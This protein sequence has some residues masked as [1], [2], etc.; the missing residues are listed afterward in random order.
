MYWIKK[1]I[2]ILAYLLL[3][4]TA[5]MLGNTLLTWLSSAEPTINSTEFN[6]R[7]QVHW[8]S[9]SKALHYFY[10]AKRAVSLRV[11]S[12]GIFASQPLDSEPVHYA[13]E[14]KLLDASE[15]V[16]YQGVYHH[17]AK[18]V[19]IGQ[20]QQVKQII[21]DREVLH[22]ASGQ[23]FYLPREHVANATVLSLRLIPESAQLQG[24]VVRVH[25]KTSNSNTN[26]TKAWLQR[27]TEWRQRVMNYHSIGATALTDEEKF[28]AVRYDWQKLAPQGL[29]NVGFKA[30]RLYESLP[31]NVANPEFMSQVN[32]DKLV[33]D[34][35][36]QVS[37]RAMPGSYSVVANDPSALQFMWHDLTQQQA[38]R[39]L[40]SAPVTP[41][42]AKVSITEPGLI[43][44]A[45]TAPQ[46][47]EIISA[48]E[49]KI[50]PLHSYYYAISQQQ[51]VSFN[52]EPDSNLALEWR[53]PIG[54]ELTIKLFANGQ[55]QEQYQVNATAELS[56]FDRLISEDTQRLDI[57]E[58]E[59]RYLA[60]ASSIDRIEI[61]SEQALVRLQ[62]RND[63]FHYRRIR[64]L[65]FCQPPQ[66]NQ[67]DVNA[68]FNQDAIDHHLFV[69]QQR[70]ARVRLF[71]SPP[72]IPEPLPHY[73]SRDL[74][75]DLTTSAVALLPISNNYYQ[76]KTQ[77]QEYE[78]QQVNPAEITQLP[79]APRYPIDVIVQQTAPPFLYETELSR[80]EPDTTM[81]RAFINYGEARSHR[82]VRLY[83]LDQQQPLTL[84]LNNT[85]Q[86]TALIIKVFNSK[87]MAEIRAD[88]S[89][90]GGPRAH[91]SD[92]Y[93]I[94]KRTEVLTAQQPKEQL[95]LHPNITKL[96]EYPAISV[97]LN[98]DL[99]HMNNISVR[100]STPVWLSIMAQH[101]QPT[102]TMNWWRNEHP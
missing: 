12:N 50:R 61:H 31:F 91:F 99:K 84:N 27:P 17:A 70:L 69:Q 76:P 82:K 51:S 32:L 44:I 94:S 52:V 26:P 46:A 47:I 21:E 1:S 95:F 20:Q 18:A 101:T 30:D 23:S 36:R 49:Q 80:L 33:V 83:K 92:H 11:L 81:R 62:S 71:E 40:T 67:G 100:F 64:C 59:R 6:T 4:A 8:L 24:V 54:T 37:F 34:G 78:Y 22:V 97:I 68:W 28:N 72:E 88:V 2:I 25:A 43:T 93:T 60:P 13:I 53:A 75:A 58:P 96:Y 14:Y 74:S 66:A 77:L 63:N 79:T 89:L 39:V 73:A 90:S 56:P 102:P 87:P 5:V 65:E 35:H 57:N 16:V 85:P 98:E 38:P 10:P 3:A 42:T 19:S 29:P 48:D 86:P 45:A 15:Q 9:D 55:L 41:E 7:S